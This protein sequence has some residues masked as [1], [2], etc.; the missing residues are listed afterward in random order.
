[1]DLNG[2]VYTSANPVRLI[3]PTPSLADLESQLAAARAENVRLKSRKTTF[4]VTDK[5]DISIYFLGSRFPAT[6]PVEKLEAVLSVAEETKAFM[7]ANRV[8]LDRIAAAK[9]KK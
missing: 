2:V 6:F 9:G 4:K 8:E 7:A 3:T 1:M 5:G